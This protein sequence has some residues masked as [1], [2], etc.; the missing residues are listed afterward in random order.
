MMQPLQY[1]STWHS[2]IGGI[3]LQHKKPVTTES[4]C[5][6]DSFGVCIETKRKKER[7]FLQSSSVSIISVARFCQAKLLM[8]WHFSCNS[9]V[10]VQYGLSFIH[11][12]L[13]PT[14]C[15]CRAHH[16]TGGSHCGCFSKNHDL[17]YGTSL[18][19]HG[20]QSPTGKLQ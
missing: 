5:I 19:K 18:Q 6:M 14:T 8:A 10:F 3:T 1:N 13:L 4:V 16:S 17:Q 15:L 7:L 2:S 20:H 11:T 12:M 9:Y